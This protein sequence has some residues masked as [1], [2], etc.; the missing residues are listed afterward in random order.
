MVIRI[1]IHYNSYIVFKKR[2]A[3]WIQNQISFFLGGGGHKSEWLFEYKFKFCMSMSKN[4]R[5]LECTH[6]IPTLKTPSISE[7]LKYISK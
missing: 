7:T 5:P 1:Q 3:I 6:C 2:M 4:A